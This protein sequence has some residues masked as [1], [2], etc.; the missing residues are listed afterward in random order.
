MVWFKVD[1]TLAA[2]AKARRAGLAA[3]GL[4]VL[5]GSHCGQQLTDGFVPEWF[6]VLWPSGRKHAAALVEAGLWTPATVDGEDGWQFH[7]WQQSNPMREQVMAERERSRQ[8]QQQWRD[9]HRTDPTSHTVRNGVTD[10]V[11]NSAPTR[12]DPT[13]PEST[14]VGGELTVVEDDPTSA[15]I[16]EHAAAYDQPPPPSALIPVKRAVMR[17]VAEGVTPDRISAGLTRMRDRRLGPGLLPQL[18]TE[19]GPAKSTTDQRVA[20]GLAL[21][22]K[23]EAQ[24]QQ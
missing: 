24:E 20:Q 18:V 22:A 6:V 5:A 14:S 16:R 17:L 23:Y 7:E 19:T 15:L 21:V 11:S 9:K 12:P 8:R 3:M 2:H 1:D 4:W 13:R 10:G